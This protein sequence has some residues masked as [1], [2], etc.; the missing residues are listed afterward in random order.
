MV[1]AGGLIALALAVGAPVALDVVAGQGYDDAIPALRLQAWA[2]LASFVLA[3][4]AFALLSLRLH[5]QI[6][7]ANV[8]ALATSAVLT[9]LLAPEEG[10]TGAGVATLVGESV[11]MLTTLGLLV[12]ARPDLRPHLGVVVKTALALGA[13]LAAALLSGLPALPATIV[14]VA[15]YTGVVL[16]TRAVPAELRDLLPRR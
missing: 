2:L 14:A 13:G 10:A 15:V 6:A 12:H 1:I 9:L 3:P 4:A 7:G 11:L 16:A 5:R 8:L